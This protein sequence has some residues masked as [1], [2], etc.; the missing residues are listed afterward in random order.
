[1][2]ANTAKGLQ[3]ILLYFFKDNGENESVLAGLCC[4]VPTLNKRIC[5]QL[6]TDGL[7]LC[8]LS[9]V[10]N[11]LTKAGKDNDAKVA[12]TDIY[13]GKDI[14]TTKVKGHENATGGKENFGEEDIKPGHKNR[15]A[16]DGEDKYTDTI[17]EKTAQEDRSKGTPEE[18]NT[19]SEKSTGGSED[20]GDS[21]GLDNSL[22]TVEKSEPEVEEPPEKKE[23]SP[24]TKLE[25][26]MTDITQIVVIKDKGQGSKEQKEEQ[27]NGKK[28][29]GK[30]GPND[31]K[32]K[33]TT[34]DGENTVEIFT[35]EKMTNNDTVEYNVVGG[36]KENNS[37]DSLVPKII[38]TRVNITYYSACTAGDEDCGRPKEKTTVKEDKADKDSTEKTKEELEKEKEKEREKEANQSFTG[39]TH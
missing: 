19:G 36:Q 24:D 15:T 33:A 4:D 30:I 37:I 10:N 17:P 1:M 34:G 9:T 2:S 25:T 12:E 23:E 29:P 28:D 39:K 6:L 35:L 27:V 26:E 22:N 20:T 5:N 8:P 16:V 7:S 11:T 31:T 21:K 14:N 13:S 32:L 18:R 3:L 38:P